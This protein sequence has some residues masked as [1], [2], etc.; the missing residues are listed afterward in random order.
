MAKAAKAKRNI[1][2][3]T[4]TAETIAS[5]VMTEGKNKDGNKRATPST[6]VFIPL[7]EDRRAT[8]AAGGQESVLVIA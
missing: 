8:V 3:E 7:E 2:D 5:V 4:K 6:A 1:E